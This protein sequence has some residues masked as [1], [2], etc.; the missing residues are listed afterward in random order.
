MTDT[1]PPKPRRS[2]RWL[3][4]GS[5][6]LNLLVIGAVA[7]AVLSGGP[8]RDSP[9]GERMI[10][11]PYV[12]AF[13]RDD[14][15]AMRDAMRKRLPRRS[16]MMA[17]NSGDYATFVKLLRATPFDPVQAT[18]VMDGQMAR[19]AE[20]TK[21]GRDLAIDRLAAMSADER[22]AYADRLEEQIQHM[23]RGHKGGDRKD[24]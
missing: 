15:R 22:A 14:K 12:N 19:V 5:L 7:G 24:H 18:K 11:S 16:V 2:T 21:L 3:L 20:T 17:A 6:A 8:R 23:G 1:Q 10:S 4:I 9:P 13:E